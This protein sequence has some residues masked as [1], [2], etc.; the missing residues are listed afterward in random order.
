M[1]STVK[2]FE[3]LPKNN[4]YGFISEFF[5]FSSYTFVPL[6]YKKLFLLFYFRV[7]QN[8][9]FKFSGKTKTSF[10]PFVSLC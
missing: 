8:T 9:C 7:K 3:I 2:Y 6:A 1:L 4:G 10:F 5:A